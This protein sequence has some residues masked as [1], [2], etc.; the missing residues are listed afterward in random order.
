MVSADASFLMTAMV[1]MVTSIL[2]PIRGFEEAL[3][4]I[5]SQGVHRRAG[6]A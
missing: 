5:A 4:K 2:F 6:H 1:A 3:V